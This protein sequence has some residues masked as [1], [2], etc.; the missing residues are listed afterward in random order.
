MLLQ[1]EL[2]SDRFFPFA[3][4]FDDQKYHLLIFICIAAGV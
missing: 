4:F 3:F 1:L 2:Q